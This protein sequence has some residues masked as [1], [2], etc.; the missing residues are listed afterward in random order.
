M[1]TYKVINERTGEV[2]AELQSIELAKT[3]ADQLAAEL[4]DVFVVYEVRRVYEKR[5]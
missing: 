1:S 3:R 2:L 5:P 4:N